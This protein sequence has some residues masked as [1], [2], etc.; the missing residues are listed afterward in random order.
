MDSKTVKITNE[1]IKFCM[2]I[3]A[4]FVL[5]PS[6]NLHNQAFIFKCK[7]FKKKFKGSSVFLDCFVRRIVIYYL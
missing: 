3:A 4:N 1:I 7:I 5:F 2:E 6:L